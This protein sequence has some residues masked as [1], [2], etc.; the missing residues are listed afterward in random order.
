MFDMS[1]VRKGSTAYSL[2][3]EKIGTIGDVGAMHFKCDTGFLGL[4]KD[5]YIP[6]SNV[7]HVTGD[8]VYLNVTKSQLNQMQWDREPAGWAR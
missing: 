3:G 5:F 6:F 2:D 1:N 8:Q 4:G 7:D